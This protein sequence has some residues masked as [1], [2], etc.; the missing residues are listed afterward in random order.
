MRQLFVL[1]TLSY[2]MSIHAQEATQ[3]FSYPGTAKVSYVRTWE[4]VVPQ[5]NTSN[6]TFS[7]ALTDYRITTQFVD[8]LSR[9][10]QVVQKGYTTSGKDFVSANVYDEYGEEP[11]KYL[12]FASASSDGVFKMDPFDEQADYLGS[13]T[14]PLKLQNENWFYGITVSEASPLNR[15][16]ESFAPGDSWAGTVYQSSSSARKSTKV[17]YFNNTVTDSVRLW[18]VQNGTNVG[19]LDHTVQTQPILPGSFLR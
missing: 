11:T 17:K 3:P 16:K 6:I 1:F 10:L 4:S 12:P 8:G 15:V 18:I 19:D 14:G 9:P 7:S 5:T 2:V 13:T